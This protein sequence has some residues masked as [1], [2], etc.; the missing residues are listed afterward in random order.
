MASKLSF[1]YIISIIFTAGNDELQEGNHAWP[2]NFQIP[3]NVPSSFEGTVGYIR[4]SITA[5]ADIPMAFDID[6]EIYISINCPLDLN[7]HAA[8]IVSCV[9]LLANL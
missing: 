3:Q 1:S 9:F 4:Y 2:F 6:R 8:A 7:H 5:K